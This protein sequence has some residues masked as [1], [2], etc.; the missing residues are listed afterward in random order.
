MDGLLSIVLFTANSCPHCPAA[1]KALD[2]LEAENEKLVITVVNIDDSPHA[3]AMARTWE[4]NAVPHFIFI[5]N[6]NVQERISEALTKP[7]IEEYVTRFI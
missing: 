2:E 1:K 7:Q 3:R 4:I 5:K 6:R